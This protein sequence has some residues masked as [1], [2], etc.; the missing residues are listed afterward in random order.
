MNKNIKTS[1]AISA[2]IIVAITFGGLIW[3]A[4]KDINSRN[5]IITQP[6]TYVDN[7]KNNKKQVQIADFISTY[8]TE[9]DGTFETTRVGRGLC[10]FKDKS[11]CD[12][13]EYF[14][15]RC[16]YNG[17]EIIKSWNSYHNDKF[18]FELQYPD[19]FKMQNEIDLA[20]E[21]Y[22]D[23]KISADQLFSVGFDN[24]NSNCNAIFFGSHYRIEIY[25]TKYK[26]TADWFE[27]WRREAEKPY[28]F[29]ATAFV[30]PKV[31]LIDD[32]KI[33]NTIGKKIHVDGDISN[34][35]YRLFGIVNN[36]Y[37]YMISY[38]G[39]Y[40]DPYNSQKSEQYL[41]KYAEI[42]D[43]IMSNFKFTN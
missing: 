12:A 37:L 20:D 17:N 36:G 6:S 3:L 32:F 16:V 41:E 40:C 22:A 43:Q 11:Y 7:N 31:S 9:H 26:N 13:E 42:L 2:I 39:G 1:V 35:N 5:S 34:R 23:A 21:K 33:Q 29:E 10:K 25:K 19:T 15:G 30:D 8:C 14:N 38:W 4:G 24:I 27:E 18:G 28:E